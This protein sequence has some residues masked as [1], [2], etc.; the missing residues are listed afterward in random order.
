MVH[1]CGNGKD[2]G[3]IFTKASS[4][5]VAAGGGIIWNTCWILKARLVQTIPEKGRAFSRKAR[6]GLAYEFSEV[7]MYED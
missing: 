5:H 1:Y 4:L 2:E 7:K 3:T 6:Y